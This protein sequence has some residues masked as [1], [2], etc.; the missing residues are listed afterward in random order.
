MARSLIFPILVL[1]SAAVDGQS[2][3]SSRRL[4]YF[5]RYGVLA[6]EE[7]EREQGQAHAKEQDEA[8]RDPPR[9]EEDEWEGLYD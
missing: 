1:L 5:Q 6:M 3:A 9:E 4:E 8:R 7:M 2:G